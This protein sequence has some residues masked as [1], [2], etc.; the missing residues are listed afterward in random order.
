MQGMQQSIERAHPLASIPRAKR[1]AYVR[2]LS[3]AQR[4]ELIQAINWYEKVYHGRKSI[5]G[6]SSTGS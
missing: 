4:K 1:T 2:S 6:K 5:G 3:P